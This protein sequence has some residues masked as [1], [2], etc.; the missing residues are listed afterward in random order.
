ME[1]LVAEYGFTPAEAVLAA[2]RAS[3]RA[4]GILA[5]HGTIEPGKAVDLIVLRAD[6]TLDIRNSEALELV[7]KSGRP[8]PR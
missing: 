7:I 5:T 2:T 3:A 8:V 1:T 4:L 6:A